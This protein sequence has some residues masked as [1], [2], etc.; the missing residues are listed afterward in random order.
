[1]YLDKPWEGKESKTYFPIN[2]R[3]YVPVED[4]DHCFP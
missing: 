3:C 4:E 2:I 1:M